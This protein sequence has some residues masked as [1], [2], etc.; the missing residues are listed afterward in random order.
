MKVLRFIMY[1]L[2]FTLVAGALLLFF[3]PQIPF[4]PDAE[5]KIVKS[6]SMEPTIMTGAAVLIVAEPVY[7]IGDVITFTDTNASIPTTHRIIAREVRE[8]ETI[9]ITQGDA[10]EDPDIAPVYTHQILGRVVLDIPYVGFIFDFARQ[11]LGFTLLVGIPALLIII[12]EVEKIVAEIRRRRQK[13]VATIAVTPALVKELDEFRASDLRFIA[14]FSLS[15]S[16]I[17]IAGLT[18]SGTLA[19]ARDTETAQGNRLTATAVDVALSLSTS[20]ATF[21]GGGVWPMAPVAL[22]IDE[23]DSDPRA[24][25]RLSVEAVGGTQAFCESLQVDISDAF[26]YSGGLLALASADFSATSVHTFI[27]F[28]AQ[29]PYSSTDTCVVDFILR[30]SLTEGEEGYFD[31][32]RARLTLA[33][34]VG[35]APARLPVSESEVPFDA[36]ARDTESEG[37]HD[38]EDLPEVVAQNGE[39]DDLEPGSVSAEETLEDNSEEAGVVA[40]HPEAVEEE[41]DDITEPGDEER[42]V[43]ESSADTEAETVPAA[44][45]IE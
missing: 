39:G 3:S 41:Q 15:V 40:D 23:S 44:E 17:A 30:A 6:G 42:E 35:A 18:L 7:E 27:S 28:D 26:V 21:I 33:V 10:N 4:G 13:P 1:S 36:V 16:A 22:Y 24:V 29:H 45:L 31:E 14:I 19:F 32:E 20:S 8:G 25:Y 5:V 11:P 34:A 12:D 37:S 43:T 2:F 38:S 9:F